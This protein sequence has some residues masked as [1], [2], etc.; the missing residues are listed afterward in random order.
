MQFFGKTQA[1]SRQPPVEVAHGQVG[2]FHMDG[3]MPQKGHC[4][5]YIAKD[6][7][8]IAIGIGQLS[9][10]QLFLAV[11]DHFQML[12]TGQRFFFEVV[13]RALFPVREPCPMYPPSP[14]RSRCGRRWQGAGGG[15]CRC[16]APA[17]SVHGAWHRL[18]FS[19]RPSP[20]ASGCP[21]PVLSPA[22]RCLFQRFRHVRFFSPL[23]CT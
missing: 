21:F 4:L 7:L 9:R 5:A 11:F 8:P 1:F 19:Q 2:S 17:F 14:R 13:D 6:D 16:V 23:C 22:K 15:P 12:P 18:R 10:R 20:L 3:A